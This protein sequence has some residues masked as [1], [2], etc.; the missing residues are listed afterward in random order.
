[1]ALASLQEFRGHSEVFLSAVTPV[2]HLF[3]NVN[4]VFQSSIRVEHVTTKPP[5]KANALTA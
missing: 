3:L 1:L 2:G 4:Y 5:V